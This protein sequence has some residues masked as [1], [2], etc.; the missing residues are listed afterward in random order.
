MLPIVMQPCSVRTVKKQIKNIFREL[1]MP[2]RVDFI[3]A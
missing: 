1:H 3:W 2:Q